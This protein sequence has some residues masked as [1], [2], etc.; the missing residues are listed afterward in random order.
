MGRVTFAETK[1]TRR[2]DARVPIKSIAA[3]QLKQLI[4]YKCSCEPIIGLLVFLS[5]KKGR[6]G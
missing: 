5:N 6:Y 3:E 4:K 2:R 1:V